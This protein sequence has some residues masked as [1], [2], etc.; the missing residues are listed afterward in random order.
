MKWND[1]DEFMEKYGSKT[2]PKAWRSIG[3]VAGYFE[4]IG[5]LV[6]EKLLDISL[7]EKLL[8]THLI[9]FWEKFEFL[10]IRLRRD[11]N[12]PLLDEWKEYLYT[13]IKKRESKRKKTS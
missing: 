3:S 4:G 8:S 13:E 9:Y 5:L 12:N 2:N 1:Y 7:V 11:F 10:S 6:N